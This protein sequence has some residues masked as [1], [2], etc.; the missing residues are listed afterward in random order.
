MPKQA[1]LFVG[2]IAAAVILVVVLRLI[3]SQ[4]AG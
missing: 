1:R 3:K 2:V 4:S